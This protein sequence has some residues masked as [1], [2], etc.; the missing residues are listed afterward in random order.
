MNFIVEINKSKLKSHGKVCENN[1]FCRIVIPSENQ[2]LKKTNSQKTSLKG[3]AFEKLEFIAVLH[4]NTR[5][6]HIVYNV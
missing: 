1:A 4:V 5:V 2:I 6:Q 3:K